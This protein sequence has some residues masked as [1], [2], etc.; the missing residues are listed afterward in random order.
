MATTTEE[1]EPAEGVPVIR[2][3]SAVPP[4][5]QIIDIGQTETSLGLLLLLQAAFPFEQRSEIIY[6]QLETGESC[7]I[8][9]S[10][11]DSLR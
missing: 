6:L 1:N 2:F 4:R 5:V 7:A 8:S 11:I 10:D 9:S 3:G